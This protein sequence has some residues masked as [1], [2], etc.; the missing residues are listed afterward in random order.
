MGKLSIIRVKEFLEMDIPYEPIIDG[1]IMKGDTL[2]IKAQKKIGKSVIALQLG[3]CLSSGQPFLNSFDVDSKHNVVY[4]SGEG[5]RGNW[6]KRFIDMKK[7]WDIDE[8]RI[9][10]CEA[11]H[12]ELQTK[13]GGQMLLKK[14]KETGIYFDIFIFDP[15]YR[16]LTDGEF[17]SSK[18]MTGFFNNVEMIQ[19]EY[20][21]TSIIVHHDSEKI[22]RDKQ[23]KVHASASS[24][25]AMGSSVTGFAVTGWYTLSDYKDQTGKKIHKLETG[26]CDRG[27]NMV[28]DIDMYMVIPQTDP[29]GRLGYTLDY[30]EC[31]ASYHTL[32]EFMKK[33]KEISDHKTYEHKE[34]KMPSRTF[35]LNMKKLR[36]NKPHPIV[37][38]IKRDG[39]GYYVYLEQ[40]EESLQ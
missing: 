2:L 8:G 5:Y 38:K 4:I 31:N 29:A 24:K 20:D 12:M 11:V 10:F 3:C 33:H 28:D 21:G 1:I 34:L 36:E 15:L 32:Y 7:M 9:H 27:G 30:D 18:D 13:E 40:P 17:S 35:Y 25:T 19:K 23:G 39:K 22:H 26:D 37:D 14:L 16:F 6:Q